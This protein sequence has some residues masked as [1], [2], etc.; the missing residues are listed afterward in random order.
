MLSLFRRPT[1]AQ[2]QRF[3]SPSLDLPMVDDTAPIPFPSAGYDL[4]KALARPGYVSEGRAWLA[5]RRAVY[6]L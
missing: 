5:R 2:P 6:F 4:V 1:S 3:A